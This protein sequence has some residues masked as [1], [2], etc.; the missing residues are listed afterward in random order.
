MVNTHT[1]SSILKA[2]GARLAVDSPTAVSTVTPTASPTA[3][4]ASPLQ[5]DAAVAS[6]LIGPP[7]TVSSS[8][9]LIGSP[10]PLIILIDRGTASSAE[11]FAAALHD[12]GAAV[13][14]GESTFGKGLVQRVFPL[15]NGG[16]LKLTIG[17]YFRPNQERIVRGTG[18][19]PDIACVASPTAAVNDACIQHAARL[20]FSAANEPLD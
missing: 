4:P 14:L 1:V 8:P 3:S 18:L 16:A 19:Q 9:R 20:V 6:T 13:L 11:L 17:E 10:K 2:H 15:P 5:A 7:A 12:N